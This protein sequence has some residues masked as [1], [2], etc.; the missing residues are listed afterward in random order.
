MTKEIKKCEHLFIISGKYI[1]IA[2][3]PYCMKYFIKE[4]PVYR[5]KIREK[6]QWIEVKIGD[7]KLKS[8]QVNLKSGQ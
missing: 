3:C 8:G 4:I 1:R 6:D 5:G 7:K 2:F